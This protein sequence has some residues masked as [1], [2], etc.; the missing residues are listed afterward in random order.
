MVQ[1]MIAVVLV[2]IGCVVQAEVAVPKPSA[3]TP[4]QAAM[5][6]ILEQLR[7]E[8]NDP[9]TREFV[10]LYQDIQR[11]TVTK[12]A[13]RRE[14]FDLSARE[15]Q[16]VRP[17]ANL[18]ETDRDPVDVVLR[19]TRALWEDLH[20]RTDLDRAGERLSSLEGAC[21]SVPTKD[22]R[23]RL[24]LFREAVALRRSIA[25]ANPLLS[26]LDRILFIT[27]CPLPLATVDGGN[28][29][30]DQFF[31]FHGTRQGHSKGDGLY[32]LE[33]PFS[34]KPT[35]RNLLKGVKVQNGRLKGQEL[36]GGGFLSPELSFDGKTILFAW[37]QAKWDEKKWRVW[38]PETTYHVFKVNA[39]GSN[40]VQ[41]TDGAWNDFDP[42]WLPNGRIMFISE[43][44]GG[45]GRCHG[46]SVPNYTLHS[47]LD[48]GSDIVLL[49][50]HETNEWQ[51]SVDNNG[52]VV[53]TR[54]DYVDRGFNQAHH[55]WL[56]TPDGRDPRAL[57]GNNHVSQSTAPDMEMDIRSVPGSPL[58]VAV[59]AAH[60]GEARG[61]LILIDPRL[62]DDNHMSQIKRLTPDQLFPETEFWLVL[63]SGSYATPWPLSETYHLC[64]YE[65]EANN[66]YAPIDE[67][68]RNYGI[69]LLDAFG[70]KEL[71]YRNPEIS[72]LSPIP[73]RPRPLPPVM[74][75]G[76]LIGLPS[77]ASGVKTA[78]AAPAELPRTAKVGCMNVYDSRYPFPPG[79]KITHLRIWQVMPK[80]TPYDN[81]PRMGM[82]S[83][84]GAKACLGTV[85]VEADGSAYW[86]QPV[87]VPILFHA[88]DAN[89][90]A[91]Q[92]MRSATYVKPGE[93]LVCNGCHDQRTTAP[94]RNSSPKAMSRAP[95][96]ITPDMDGSNP[97]N[98]PRLVQPILDSKCVSCH[99]ESRAK[100]GKAPDLSRGENNKNQDLFYTSFNSLKPFCFFYDDAGFTQ[101]STIPGHFGAR[102]SKLYKLLS[103]GHHKV[104]LMP[105]EMRRL[106][107]WLDSNCLFYGHEDN[108][109]AQSD[110]EIVQ[111][112]LQ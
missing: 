29:M 42:C 82:G 33:N 57:N 108:I 106:T 46:R 71:L 2:L 78:G 56:T 1:R 86:E 90:M 25:F 31:G 39:D 40:L 21:R 30:C 48:D 98:Y 58:Y 96:R 101:A 112:S 89:G 15:K 22:I 28:H 55:A 111:P 3:V 12:G 41:L 47:M 64:V 110:G 37:T 19:R 43:R 17:A 59:A 92:G 26:G 49:S 69:V 85:P 63:P 100:G 6:P 9:V 79:T 60:H 10:G 38:T 104:K 27:R 91:V 75:H 84:K 93:V 65:R 77:S 68:A 7:A 83:Q 102:E 14:I 45:Y 35:V 62:P 95:S 52:M 107:L 34:E 94:M 61:S 13:I 32:V 76:T 18:L 109:K 70:N 97:F 51:P 66:Q 67:A 105:E 81:R 36:A 103:E 24:E 54:W 88:L 73:F 20:A 99:T 74:P 87:G 50:P 4:E 44:R 23:A 5:A 8:P 80:T 72:C 11:R 53:Y 16:A